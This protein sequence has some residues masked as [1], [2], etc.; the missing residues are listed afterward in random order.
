MHAD[1]KRCKSYSIADILGLNDAKKKRYDSESSSSP[2][3]S[4]SRAQSPGQESPGSLESPSFSD[5][6][7]KTEALQDGLASLRD[8]QNGIPKKRRYRTT[9]TTYQLDELER[10]FVRTHYPD[11]FLREELAM[12]LNLTEARIQVWFQNRR[13]KWR[14]RNKHDGSRASSPA[15]NNLT[16]L[17]QTFHSNVCNSLFLKTLNHTSHLSTPKMPR[18]PLIPFAKPMSTCFGGP[19]CTHCRNA[20]HV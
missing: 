5:G 14:K 9:F 16:I 19:S 6:E 3:S 2:D 20:I 1:K 11:V 15:S 12:K 13:A 18:L 8:Q 10:V 4:P 7:K 17:P